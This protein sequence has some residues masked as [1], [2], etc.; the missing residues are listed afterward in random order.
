MLLEAIVESTKKLTLQFGDLIRKLAQT[1]AQF[2]LRLWLLHLSPPISS[3]AARSGFVE[4]RQNCHDK[5]MGS[6]LDRYIGVTERNMELRHVFVIMIKKFIQCVDVS[7]VITY[8]ETLLFCLDWLQ[9]TTMN[10]W[11]K[12]S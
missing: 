4:D 5:A 12:H 11:L 2:P 8:C 3:T 9:H 10:S 6:K 7:A 1:L